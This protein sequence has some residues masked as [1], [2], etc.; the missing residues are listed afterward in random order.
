[1]NDV[2]D[3]RGRRGSA[4]LI[5]RNEPV[6]LSRRNYRYQLHLSNNLIWMLIWTLLFFKG[7]VVII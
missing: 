1:M 3:A 7:N 6:L 4:F 2:F 5:L